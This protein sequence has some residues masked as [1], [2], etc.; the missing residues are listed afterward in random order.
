LSFIGENPFE[1]VEV[2]QSTQIVDEL[3]FQPKKPAKTPWISEC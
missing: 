1:F 3:G 2:D